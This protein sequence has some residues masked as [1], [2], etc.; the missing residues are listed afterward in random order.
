MKNTLV[1]LIFLFSQYT[2]S[3]S[4]ESEKAIRAGNEFYTQQQFVRAAAEYTK[5]VESDPA[6]TTARF[7][8][9]IGRASCR[10]RVCLAV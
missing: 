2:F 10:E 5:A 7:N 9:E 1:I 6:N 8:Q 4:K 3:Q